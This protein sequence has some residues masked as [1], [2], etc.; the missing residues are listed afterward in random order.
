MSDSERAKRVKSLRET[1]A[2]LP[3]PLRGFCESQKYTSVQKLGYLKLAMD[4]IE[5]AQTSPTVKVTK[6]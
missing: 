3:E 6:V 4:A 5:T 2:E 1:L